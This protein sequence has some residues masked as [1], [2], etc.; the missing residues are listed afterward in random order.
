MKYA[1]MD[2][3]FTAAEDTTTEEVELTVEDVYTY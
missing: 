1:L 3:E 2:G